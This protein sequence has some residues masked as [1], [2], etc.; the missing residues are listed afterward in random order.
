MDLTIIMPMYNVEK[1]IKQAIE[2]ISDQL[3]DNVELLVV[4]DG[5]TDNSLMVAT[6]FI[7]SLG[8][9]KNIK[10]LHK[11]NGGLSDARNFGLLNASGTYVWFF[12]SDDVMPR[13]TID[14]IMRLVNESPDLIHFEVAKFNSDECLPEQPLKYDFKWGKGI[15]LVKKLF[16]VKFPSY[17]VSYVVKKSV[18]EE[19]NFSFPFGKLYEDLFTTFRVFNGADNIIDLHIFKPYYYRMNPASITAKVST[20]SLINRIEAASTI[21]TFVESNTELPW[22]LIGHIVAYVQFDMFNYSGPDKKSISLTLKKIQRRV[23]SHIS[24]KTKLK[25]TVIKWAGKS[26]IV[27]M[28]WIK[29]RSLRGKI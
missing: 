11:E 20:K 13:N 4:D 28:I 19:I 21:K 18:L 8:S 5:S 1:Y 27:R 16:K 26:Y 9:L 17:A 22:D 12:D 23:F 25:Y 6:K 24:M 15:N 7:E 14:I 10:L 2:S 29:L 3:V